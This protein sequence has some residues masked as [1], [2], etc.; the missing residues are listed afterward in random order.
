M[1]RTALPGTAPSSDGGAPGLP[2]VRH[3]NPTDPSRDQHRPRVDRL[4]LRVTKS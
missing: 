4:V 1:G 2:P 3:G